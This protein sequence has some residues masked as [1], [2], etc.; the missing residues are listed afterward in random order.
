MDSSLD[1]R[2]VGTGAKRIYGYNGQ[3]SSIGTMQTEGMGKIEA[4]T[5]DLLITYTPAGPA[6]K[7]RLEGRRRLQSRVGNYRSPPDGKTPQIG[8]RRW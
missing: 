2:A 4:K 3:A 8:S 6:L 1:A 5:Y 7:E